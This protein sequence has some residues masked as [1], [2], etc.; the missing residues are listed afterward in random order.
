INVSPAADAKTTI[1]ELHPTTD[2]SYISMKKHLNNGID[3]PSCFIA[4]HDCIALGSMRALKECGYSIPQDISIIGFDSI[5][6][7]AVSDPPLTTFY[8]PCAEISEHAVQTLFNYI[9]SKSRI[10]IK[11]MIGTRFIERSSVVK[12][13][14]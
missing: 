1:L 4:N 5:S 3:M 7:S 14:P 11:S 6:F 10:P 13:E 9:G 12:A 2:G 8:V